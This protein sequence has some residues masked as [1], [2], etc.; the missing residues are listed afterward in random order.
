MGT[1]L[2][3]YLRDKMNCL[4]VGTARIIRVGR[5][6]LMS[7]KDMDKKTVPQRKYD[8]YSIND[9]LTVHWKDNKNVTLLSTDT[10]VE[11]LECQEI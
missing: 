7:T 10:G 2:V 8:Y 4:Y 3:E 1:E 11:P 6:P 5:A 9:I